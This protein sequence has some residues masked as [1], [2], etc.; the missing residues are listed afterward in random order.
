[1]RERVKRWFL[2][3]MGLLIS[4]ASWAQSKPAITFED[5]AV[6]ASGLTP[7]KSVVWFG[8]ELRVDAEY[9]S[10]RTERYQ[11]GTVAADGTARF[12]LDQPVDRSGPPWI[13]TAVPLLWRCR[14][15]IA[16]RS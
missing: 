13:S 10:S 12:T 1:M 5:S 2:V 8:V 7:G 15:A 14:R 11:V 9:S 3:P 6:V 16:S 4:A